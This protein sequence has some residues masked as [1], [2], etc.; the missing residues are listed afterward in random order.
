[1]RPHIKTHKLPLFAEMQLGAGAFG[2]TC[3][4]VSEAAAIVAGSP[5]IRDVLITYSI[6]G[7]EKLTRLKA[8]ALKVHLSVVA[9][10][11]AVMDGLSA[12]LKTRPSRLPCWWNT[13]PAPTAAVSDI[14]R[15]RTRS[16]PI[17]MPRRASPSVA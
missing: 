3:Q 13:I 12:I 16:Q 15:R 14:R 11:R 7:A 5:V 8:L 9:D 17:S 4:K 2:I 6:V 1:M 10:S